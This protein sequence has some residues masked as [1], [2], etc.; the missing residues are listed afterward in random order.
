M[1][2]SELILKLAERNPHLYQRDVERIVSTVFD[3][4]TGA[5]AR[6]DRV[7]LR[8]FGA[9][10]VK[11]RDARTGRNPRTGASVRVAE[12]YIPFFKTG[13]QLRDRLNPAGKPA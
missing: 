2:K 6:G 11:H 1:T 9:F 10:S 7:E 12:K 8:G 3:E 5:L 4:I 13:K